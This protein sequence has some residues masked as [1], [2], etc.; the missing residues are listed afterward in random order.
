[1]VS[2]IKRYAQDFYLNPSKVLNWDVDT[3]NVQY[4]GIILA[5]KS[6]INKELASN[7]VGNYEKI[8]FL[9]NSYY[10]DDKFSINSNNPMSRI[11]IRIELYSYEDIYDLANSRNQVFFNLLKK[12]FELDNEDIL[13][14]TKLNDQ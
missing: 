3:N 10:I 14:V 12:E 4:M 5:R 6:D 8:P 13:E 7:N 9:I 1:M 2:Q 11:S